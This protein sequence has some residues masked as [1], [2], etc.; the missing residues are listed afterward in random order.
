MIALHCIL[1][2]TD[3]S[4]M[5]ILMKINYATKQNKIYKT[6]EIMPKV[7]Y[8]AHLQYLVSTLVLVPSVPLCLVTLIRMIINDKHTREENIND[9]C[10]TNNDAFFYLDIAE[11]LQA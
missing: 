8:L 2:A 4:Q 7:S 6:L 10:W 11:M 5:Y 1:A 9:I 3:I